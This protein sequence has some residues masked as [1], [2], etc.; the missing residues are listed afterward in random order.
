M[1]FNH[2]KQ[3][4]LSILLTL[5]CMV[6]LTF[7]ALCFSSELFFGVIFLSVGACEAAVG[8]GCLVG[9]IRLA[10]QSSI[11]LVE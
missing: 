6:L 2:K 7:I 5:E 10:G 9:L 3:N 11:G 4:V 8:L 1:S